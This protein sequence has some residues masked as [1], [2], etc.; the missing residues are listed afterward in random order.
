M[1][2]CVW[3][4]L[5]ASEGFL[6]YLSYFC[7]SLC[8]FFAC[9]FE[10]SKESSFKH[11]GVE[12]WMALACLRARECFLAQLDCEML[13]ADQLCRRGVGDLVSTQFNLGWQD[14]GDPKVGLARRGQ[15][16]RPS[17]RWKG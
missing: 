3:F 5:L 10:A 4:W 12:L 14:L 9:D 1:G 8:L 16:L 17:F 15:Y 2:S 13:A 11:F 7:S 6:C